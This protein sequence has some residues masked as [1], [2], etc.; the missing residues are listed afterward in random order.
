M[1]KKIFYIFLIIVFGTFID[2]LVHQSYPPFHVPFEYFP[3][4]IIFGTFWGVVFTLIAEKL[5][6][7]WKKKSIFV[8]LMVAIV[9]QTKYFF[10]GYD[11][12]FV[13]IFLFLHFFMFLP[14]SF[15]IF[16]KYLNK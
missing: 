5:S 12:S 13:V 2:F 4:K 7:S 16:K 8:P 11:L 15:I 14:A 1:L 9:L 3:N 10:Q 6:F